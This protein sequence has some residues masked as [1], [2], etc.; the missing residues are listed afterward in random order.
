VK[1]YDKVP[2]IYHPVSHKDDSPSWLR[3]LVDAAITVTVGA[4]AFFVVYL[5]WT[6]VVQPLVHE[7]ITILMSALGGR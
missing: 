5:G 2:F 6:L 4:F 1:N 3:S 7:W